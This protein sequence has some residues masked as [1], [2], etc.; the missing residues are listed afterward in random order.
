MHVCPQ[1]SL[2]KPHSRSSNAEG[3]TIDGLS[4]IRKVRCVLSGRVPCAQTPLTPGASSDDSGGSPLARNP[5]RS[6]AITPQSSAGG[7]L[8]DAAAAAAAIPRSAPEPSGSG[9]PS[10]TAP[11]VAPPTTGGVHFPAGVPEDAV[12]IGGPAL[13][14]SPPRPSSLR[15]TSGSEAAPWPPSPV[16]VA[17][18]AAAQDGAAPARASSSPGFTQ[19]PGGPRSAEGEGS[20]PGGKPRPSGALSPRSF[21]RPTALTSLPVSP[22]VAELRA[23]AAGPDEPHT[24]DTKAP[25]A[26]ACKGVMRCG[27]GLHA[28]PHTVDCSDDDQQPNLT[29]CNAH[30]TNSA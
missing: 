15:L 18:Q 13:P 28:V 11:A 6:M 2:I 25:L 21:Y 16:H 24:P 7:G 1:L 30:A 8:H 14:A 17:R 20:F 27:L 22:A 23:S 26:A 3:S 19:M 5:M 9:K 10:P 12:V 29:Y 4:G